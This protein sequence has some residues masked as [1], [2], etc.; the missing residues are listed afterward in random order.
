MSSLLGEPL[1]APKR[2]RFWEWLWQR[3]RPWYLLGVPIGAVMAL[4]IGIAVAGG[5]YAALQYSSSEAFCTSCH[6]MATPA[7]ELSH[8][9]HYSNAFGIRA[10][11]SDC[12]IPP[13]FFAGTLDHMT[14]GLR[15][16]WGHLRSTIGS[17]AKYEARRLDMAETVWAHLRADDSAEASID[18]GAIAD[19]DKPGLY[20]VRARLDTRR[21]SG[22]SIGMR[23]F[24]GELEA[25]EPMLVRVRAAKDGIARPRPTLE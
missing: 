12:H 14:S 5:G 9:V 19:F 20:V 23:T 24:D 18:V 8:R 16:S 25:K 21:A 4:M 3:P 17:P 13:G 15:D 7:E 6:E 2:R 1:N 11:C 10:R 22:A